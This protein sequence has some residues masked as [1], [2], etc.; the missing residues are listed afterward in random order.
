MWLLGFCLI[1]SSI[2]LHLHFV[3]F[4]EKN[5]TTWPTAK[6]GVGTKRVG[7]TNMQYMQHNKTL[8]CLL[9][10]F[11]DVWGN[12]WK[13]AKFQCTFLHPI[14]D[15]T[16]SQM[17]VSLASSFCYPCTCGLVWT[18]SYCMYKIY[19]KKLKKKYSVQKYGTVLYCIQQYK[20]VKYNTEKFGMLGGLTC[21][22][23]I[24][25]RGK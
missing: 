10:L 13:V 20:T 16:V 11:L 5:W 6:I 25:E 24:Q 4:Q 17:P 21:S 12:I 2:M 22:S 8:H 3:S 1:P 7:T 9:L 23:F 15:V 14:Y 19:K 18:H